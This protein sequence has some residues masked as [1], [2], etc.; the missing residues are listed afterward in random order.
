MAEVKEIIK[1][2]NRNEVPLGQG[3]CFNLDGREI[4]VFRPR[5]G[6]VCA[7]ENRCPHRQGP[8]SE[9]IIDHRVV[10]CPYH[11]HKF[12][13]QNGEGSEGG[14]KVRRF[15]VSEKHEELFLEI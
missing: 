8:L 1:L 15:S 3:R 7:I 9:G 11:G 12:N 5:S 13:L 6:R 10:V 4:A 14:E 2:G